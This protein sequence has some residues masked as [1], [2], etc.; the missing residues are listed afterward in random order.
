MIFNSQIWRKYEDNLLFRQS[1]TALFS[2]VDGMI[3]DQSDNKKSNLF[4]NNRSFS[5]TQHRTHAS[6]FRSHH[7]T[8]QR[9]MFLDTR[10]FFNTKKI[11]S[12]I[13]KTMEEN[14]TAIKEKVY[15]EVVDVL[16][17]IFCKEIETKCA[18]YEL[19][20]NNSELDISKVWRYDHLNYLFIKIDNKFVGF[21]DHVQ[22]KLSAFIYE[23]CDLPELPFWRFENVLFETFCDFFYTNLKFGTQLA[24]T[25]FCNNDK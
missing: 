19:Q 11:K 23:L 3:I 6:L 14:G 22:A 5:H 17:S 15:K 13:R 9:T 21:L 2:S 8:I 12:R 7:M 18:D 25:D 10:N 1:S 20:N 24:I 16:V 4:K